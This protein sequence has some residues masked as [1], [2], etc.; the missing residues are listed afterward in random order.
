MLIFENMHT[1]GHEGRKL[2]PNHENFKIKVHNNIS[3]NR[4]NN[5][6]TNN[7]TQNTTTEVKLEKKFIIFTF[8]I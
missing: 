3:R 1:L 7:P 6:N 2:L 5:L 4:K 8:V